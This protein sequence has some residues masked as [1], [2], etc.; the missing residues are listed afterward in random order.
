MKLRNV[1]LALLGAAVGIVGV[2]ATT[3]AVAEGEQFIPMLTYRTGPYAPSGIPIANGFRDYYKMINARDGGINGVTITSEECE[4]Q[5]NTKLG[6]E[7]YE[8]LKNKGPTGAALINPFSTGITYQLIPKAPVDGVPILSMGYGQTA[9]ADGRVF[10]WVFN[11]PTTYWS[12]ASAVIRYIAQ[13]EGGEA[14]LKGMKIAHVYHNSAYGKEANPTLEVLAEKFGFEL[15]LL[16]VDHP[17]QEQK[18]TW[19]QIRRKKPDWVFMSGWGVMNSVAVKEAAAINFPMDHFIGNWWSGSDADVIPAGAGAAGYKSAT[20]HSP[21]SDFPVHADILKHVYGGDAAKAAENNFGEVLY[22]RALVNA[23]FGVEAIRTAQGKYGNKPLTGT[24]VR[25]GLENLNVTEA[26]LAEMGMK[27]YTRPVKVSCAD[28]ESG[29]PILIQQW[30]GS[31]WSIVSDWIPVMRDVV[32]P[33][34][35][36]AAAEYA[37]E[38]NITPRDC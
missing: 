33:M 27:D 3:P 8:K 35:E 5:Y 6:V 24:Q 14:S 18:A 38:N 25:W 15:I 9:A 36:K 16:A 2:S 34:I 29:G 20:F 10:E 13:Q 30:D 21:G 32:R 23:M 19:L 28:H 11:F 17:G 1:T 37:K 22:N 12:Q 4:T 26:R 7:C 31:K